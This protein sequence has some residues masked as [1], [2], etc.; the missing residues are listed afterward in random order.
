[1]MILAHKHEIPSV[2]RKHTHFTYHHLGLEDFTL[3]GILSHNATD[4]ELG[5]RYNGLLSGTFI[6]DK[7]TILLTG[8]T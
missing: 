4:K 6:T 5:I 2:R 7:S 3:T 8:I 1:M